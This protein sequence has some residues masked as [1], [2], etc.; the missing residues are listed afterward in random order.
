M[1]DLSNEERM[2]TVLDEFGALCVIEERVTALR[3]IVPD[4]DWTPPNEGMVNLTIIME[5]VNRQQAA[6]RKALDQMRYWAL[7]E[8]QDIRN[9][10]GEWVGEDENE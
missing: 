1:S 9:D 7:R 4:K 2:S 6:Y 8:A 3:E 5:K 10:L